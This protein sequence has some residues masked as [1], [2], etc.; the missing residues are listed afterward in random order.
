MFFHSIYNSLHLL[1]PNPNPSLCPPPNP[2]TTSLISMSDQH[3]SFISFS[4][5]LFLNNSISG[6]NWQYYCLYF[7]SIQSLLHLHSNYSSLYQNHPPSSTDDVVY[8][9]V[10]FTNDFNC[11]KLICLT[12]LCSVCLL[13]FPKHSVI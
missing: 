6:L 12:L 1:I 7:I 8:Y 9:F 5:F 3:S 10:P 2:A 4:I 13:I 11:T